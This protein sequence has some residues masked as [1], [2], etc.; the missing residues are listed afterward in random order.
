LLH[1]AIWRLY[2]GI[3]PNKAVVPCQIYNLTDSR[4]ALAGTRNDSAHSY[5][6][7]SFL[8]IL[9]ATYAVI[10]PEIFLEFKDPVVVKEMI[11]LAGQQSVQST[12]YSVKVS[13]GGNF[14]SLFQDSHM[15]EIVETSFIPIKLI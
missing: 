3:L 11:I 5:F 7:F 10:H 12:T 6:F 8:S 2:Y 15:V 1:S 13:F 4:P 14:I 9:R